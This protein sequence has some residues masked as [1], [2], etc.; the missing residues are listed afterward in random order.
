M[1]WANKA[2]NEQ[3]FNDVFERAST[4][5]SQEGG[6]LSVALL[7]RG[8]FHLLKGD[9][10][11]ALEDLGKVVDNLKASDKVMTKNLEPHN[12]RLSERAIIIFYMEI[13]G[14]HQRTD[15]TS[16]AFHAIGGTDQKHA[17]L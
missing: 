11:Q 8:T 1:H 3:K 5:I 15:Q 12:I 13:V 9:H 16:I 2:L 6:D 10:M 7:L 4:E 14:S 17:R